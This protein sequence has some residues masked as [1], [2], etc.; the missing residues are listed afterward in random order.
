VP[1]WSRHICTMR[2][3]DEKN[4]A[5]GSLRRKLCAVEAGGARN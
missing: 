4:S 5:P 2:G 3:A 1:Y